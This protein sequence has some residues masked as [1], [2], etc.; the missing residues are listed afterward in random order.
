MLIVDGLLWEQEP[1]GPPLEYLDT[2]PSCVYA[3]LP[4][5]RGSGSQGGAGVYSLGEVNRQVPHLC[6]YG[7]AIIHA[8]CGMTSSRV[9]AFRSPTF[10]PL[11]PHLFFHRNPNKLGGSPK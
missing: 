10:L 5:S 3:V 11:T 9:A 8:G 1:V 7:E 2:T 4:L 6:S